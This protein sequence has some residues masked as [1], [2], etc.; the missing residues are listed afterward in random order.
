[1]ERRTMS[2]VPMHPP[3]RDSRPGWSRFSPGG[4]MH[5]GRRASAPL[6]LTVLLV[7]TTAAMAAPTDAAV[8]PTVAL[9]PNL[10]GDGGFETPVVEFADLFSAGQRMGAWQVTSGTVDLLGSAYYADS[11]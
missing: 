10:V 6:M 1:M 5:I 8:S 11:S 2:P 3:G 9:G 4:D 7:A